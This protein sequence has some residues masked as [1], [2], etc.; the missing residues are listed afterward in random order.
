MIHQPPDQAHHIAHHLLLHQ[1]V[2]ISICSVVIKPVEILD[3]ICSSALI[4]HRI[5]GP[6]WEALILVLIGPVILGL[7]MNLFVP[8][9]I[10]VAAFILLI[11]G[12][13]VCKP[14]NN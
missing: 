8:Y 13:T 9:I 2:N 7:S 5:N 6:G 14:L 10:S 1:M 11:D 4:Q 12:L 3:Q